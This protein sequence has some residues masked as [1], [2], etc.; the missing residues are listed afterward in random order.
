MIQFALLVHANITAY[1]DKQCST[2][3]FC[4]HRV[5]KM[6]AL[7]LF[8]TSSMDVHLT[9]IANIK[10]IMWM[11]IGEHYKC[12]HSIAYLLVISLLD[13]TALNG[14]VFHSLETSFVSAARSFIACSE[15]Q[16]NWQSIQMQTYQ[17]G[18][19]VSLLVR[20]HELTFD[21]RFYNLSET[22]LKK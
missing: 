20:S 17:I 22:N 8:S 14:I 9:D 18:P 19:I 7:H 6:Y 16:A 5:Y 2:G 4:E 10:W 15:T 21:L 13:C 3:C 1:S 12:L 11:V